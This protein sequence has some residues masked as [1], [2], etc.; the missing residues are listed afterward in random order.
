MEDNSIKKPE[1]K[2]F[3]SEYIEIFKSSDKTVVVE[4]QWE[5]DG[6]FFQK[7]SMYDNSYIPVESLG[8]TTLINNL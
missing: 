3:T 8:N 5:K 7:L 4:T 1:Y 6:D 2:D